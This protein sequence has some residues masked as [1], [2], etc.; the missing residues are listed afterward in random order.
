MSFCMPSHEGDRLARP[1]RR[2]GLTRGGS[3][4]GTR[5][6][7]TRSQAYPRPRG[8]LTCAETLLGIIARVVHRR[9]HRRGC[10]PARPA[11]HP[12]FEVQP[13]DSPFVRVTPGPSAVSSP[14]AGRPIPLETGPRRGFVASPRSGPLGARRTAALTRDVAPTLGRRHEGRHAVGLLLPGRLRARDGRADR[15]PG[16]RGRAPRRVRGPRTRVPRPAGR[17]PR[18]LH[19]ARP[20][21][22]ARCEASPARWAYFVAAPGYGPVQRARDPRAP[23]STWSAA[24]TREGRSA[25]DGSLDLLSRHPVR[26]GRGRRPGP[27]ARHRVAEPVIAGLRSTNGGSHHLRRTPAVPGCPPPPRRPSS[28]TSAGQ[29]YA[30]PIPVSSSGENVPLVTSPI[31]GPR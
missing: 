31:R 8:P 26:R 12:A 17:R 11:P 5:W 2:R 3:P 7:S 16:V 28:A 1:A 30:S 10:G 23:G 14:T 22:R 20:T 19:R 21:A 24:V 6:R 15:H 27:G 4:S 18:R 9:L 29:M 13:T 25:R